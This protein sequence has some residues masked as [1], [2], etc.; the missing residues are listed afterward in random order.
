MKRTHI[1]EAAELFLGILCMGLAFRIFLVPNSIAPGGVS[2]IAT[3][4]HTQWDLPVGAITIAINIPL[5]AL[6]WKMG[7]KGFMLRSLFSMVLS[8]AIID[9]LPL[10]DVVIEAAGND[11]VL[12]S[13]YGGILVGAG[14]GFVYRA[15]SST[16]GTDLA[17]ALVHRFIPFISEAWVL[18]AIDFLVVAASL[19]ILGPRIALYSLVTLFISAKVTDFFQI[20]IHA[21]KCFWIITTKGEELSNQIMSQ[22]ERGVTLLPGKGMY[23]RTPRD[24]LMCVIS[25]KEIEQLKSLAHNVDPNAFV[26]VT[27]A[28][29]ALGEGFSASSSVI[30]HK[31]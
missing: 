16:G 7:G 12:A 18:F 24:V 17:A 25:P 11:I 27:N 5:F 28:V 31:K 30:S 8:S 21:V 13:V 2:G 1:K 4:L 19:L 23:T 14:V 3:I 22:M 29:E 6:G 15:H 10:P 20:G 26:L 9:Y